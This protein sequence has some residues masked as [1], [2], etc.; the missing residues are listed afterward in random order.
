MKR[1]RL[2]ETFTNTSNRDIYYK[3]KYFNAMGKQQENTDCLKP[4]QSITKTNRLNKVTILI[5]N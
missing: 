4:L 5:N 1:L 3:V 2:Y